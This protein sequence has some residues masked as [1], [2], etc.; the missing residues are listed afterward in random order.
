MAVASTS[1]AAAAEEPTSVIG[2]RWKERK[3]EEAIKISA[4]FCYIHSMEQN[5]FLST[6]C[7]F[8]SAPACYIALSPSVGWLLKLLDETISAFSADLQAIHVIATERV[9]AVA[10]VGGT[11]SEWEADRLS[12]RPLV[13]RLLEQAK[14]LRMRAAQPALGPAL[15]AALRANAP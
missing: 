15:A 14:Q 3:R 8:S 6:L 10:G 9:R 13:V 5:L 1:A 12:A 2:R 7:D 11:L 4:L